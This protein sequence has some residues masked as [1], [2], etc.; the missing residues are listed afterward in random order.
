MEL[1]APQMYKFAIAPHRTKDAMPLVSTIVAIAIAAAAREPAAYVG[2][3]DGRLQQMQGSS[4][5]WGEWIADVER[6]ASVTKI[7]SFTVKQKVKPI[8]AIVQGSQDIVITGSRIPQP[9]ASPG[10]P[11]SFRVKVRLPWLACEEGKS[12]PT[13]IMGDPVKAYEL[14]DAVIASCGIGAE[15]G[16]TISFNYKKV[17]VRSWDPKR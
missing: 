3:N 11:G 9:S 1:Q 5:E 6:P 14:S 7:D 8:G 13:L 2:R 12:Y 16:Q 17:R 15:R 10:G 4:V